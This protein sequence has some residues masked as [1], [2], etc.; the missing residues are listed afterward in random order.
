M[1]KTISRCS[2][3]KRKAREPE[4]HSRLE[5]V[6]VTRP[7]TVKVNCQ[8]KGLASIRKGLWTENTPCL[9]SSY[10]IISSAN[11]SGRVSGENFKSLGKT[12]LPIL[13]GPNFANPERSCFC[14]SGG[15]TILP[16]QRGSN[17]AN[18]EGSQFRQS[19]EV[20]ILSIR[21]GPIFANPEGSQFCQSGRV[22]FLPI[23]GV[24]F[25]QIRRGPIFVNL[26]RQKKSK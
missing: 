20:P 8:I 25:L 14:Q 16:I 2:G 18:P 4:N 26:S 24:L 23:R 19:G 10:S 17:F 13:R 5:T 15:V 22:L 21:R 11:V 7:F 3:Q 1:D 12:I 6:L 9:V